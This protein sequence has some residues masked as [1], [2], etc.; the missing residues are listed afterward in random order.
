VEVERTDPLYIHTWPPSPLLP[1]PYFPSL[2]LSLFKDGKRGTG[3]G[4]AV[5]SH[6]PPGPRPALYELSLDFSPY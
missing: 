3:V 6:P 1:T 5:A 4:G 2:I